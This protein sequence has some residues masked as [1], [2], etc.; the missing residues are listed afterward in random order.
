MLAGQRGDPLLLLKA[1]GSDADET[2]TRVERH[3]ERDLLALV[4]RSPR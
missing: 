1:A 2:G 4:Y 3:P